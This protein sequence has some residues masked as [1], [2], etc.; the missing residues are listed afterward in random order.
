MTPGW[1][2]WSSSKQQ[3][4]QQQ[5]GHKGA[6]EPADVQRLANATV[7]Q[8]INVIVD[9]NIA[10]CKKQTSDTVMEAGYCNR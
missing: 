6:D 4:Q 9:K 10:R 1:L 2:F 8:C 3:Q 5:L 7:G